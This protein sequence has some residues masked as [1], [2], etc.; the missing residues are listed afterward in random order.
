MIAICRFSYIYPPVIAFFIWFL[1]LVIFPIIFNVKIFPGIEKRLGKKIIFNNPPFYTTY[2]YICSPNFIHPLF[3]WADLAFYCLSKA[4]GTNMRKRGA[5]MNV[6]AYMDFDIKL[7]TKMEFNLS[8]AAAV[9]S[10]S[11]FLVMGFSTFV[12]HVYHCKY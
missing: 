4:I 12:E 5:R 11:I 7:L 1:V 9:I 8:V 6:F 2:Y 10:M 3:W